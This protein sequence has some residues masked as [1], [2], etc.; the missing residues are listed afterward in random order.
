VKK[1]CEKVQQERLR[2]AFVLDCSRVLST[3]AGYEWVWIDDRGR[4][5]HT[6]VL[7]CKADEIQC[8]TAREQ[9]HDRERPAQGSEQVRFPMREIANASAVQIHLR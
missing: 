1:T 2:G 8:W 3:A 4:T 5:G 9:R 6:G 7:L